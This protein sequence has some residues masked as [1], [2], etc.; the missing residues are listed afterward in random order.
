MFASCPLVSCTPTPNTPPIQA[1]YQ[2]VEAQL[3]LHDYFNCLLKQ[4]PP[5]LNEQKAILPRMRSKLLGWLEKL[6]L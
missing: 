5:K 4:E 1:T 6:A 3:E 2:Q